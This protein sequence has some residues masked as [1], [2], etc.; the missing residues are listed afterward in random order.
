[1]LNHA[2][3]TPAAV[4]DCRTKGRKRARGGTRRVGGG[5]EFGHGLPPFT[6]EEQ[7]NR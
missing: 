5:F 1:M 2:M 7:G 6:V 3:N 4:Y